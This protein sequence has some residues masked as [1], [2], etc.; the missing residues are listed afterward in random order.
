M[1]RTIGSPGW[2]HFRWP[3]LQ[4]QRCCRT[5]SRYAPRSSL[6]RWRA[7]REWMTRQTELG[8]PVNR[9][10]AGVK[11]DCVGGD[12]ATGCLPGCKDSPAWPPC[13]RT[14]NDAARTRGCRMSSGSGCTAALCTDNR[15]QLPCV[16]CPVCPMCAALRLC[17]A[18]APIVDGPRA[19]LLGHLE[20]HPRPARFALT[21]FSIAA[22]RGSERERERC[23]LS[24]SAVRLQ[25]CCALC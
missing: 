25:L 20:P 24:H 19:Y 17:R 14:C 6:A 16:P 4:R 10:R 13:T 18:P 7:C 8:E 15:A 3:R 21:R 5:R 12:N 23:V 1:T 22:P 11:C 9:C 2:L